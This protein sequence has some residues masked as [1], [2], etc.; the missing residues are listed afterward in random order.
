MQLK[1]FYCSLMLTPTFFVQKSNFNCLFF[2]IFLV[3]GLIILTIP[4]GP[5]LSTAGGWLLPATCVHWSNSKHGHC[6]KEICLHNIHS[7]PGILKWSERR[8]VI[9]SCLHALVHFRVDGL[10]N[11]VL[12]MLLSSQ[13]A[14]NLTSLCPNTSIW[15]KHCHWGGIYSTKGAYSSS[16]K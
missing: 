2:L 8:P 4:P 15:S 12:H 6:T 7:Q 9:I 3:T 16:C 11:E 10:I 14:T 5:S 1:P 13:L